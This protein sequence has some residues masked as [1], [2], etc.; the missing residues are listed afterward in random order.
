VVWGCCGEYLFKGIG[1]IEPASPGFRTVT[2]KPV[3][4]ESLSWARARYNSISG[5]IVSAWRRDTARPQDGV[6][7]EV[8]IPANVTALVHVPSKGPVLESGKPVEKACGVR[9]V[10]HETEGDVY[11]VGSGHYVF[12]CQE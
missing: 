2:I 12:H 7:L 5:D 8:T 1:G 10:K 11:Q 4:T 9:L 3:F 6:T